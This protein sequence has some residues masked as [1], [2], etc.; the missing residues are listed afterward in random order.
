MPFQ[1]RKGNSIAVD[2]LCTVVCVFC[3]ISPDLSYVCVK[4]SRIKKCFTPKVQNIHDF[5]AVR[6]ERMVKCSALPACRME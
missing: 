1:G 4:R 5:S 2:F 6:F 3:P